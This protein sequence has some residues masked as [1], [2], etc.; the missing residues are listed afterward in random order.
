MTGHQ[1]HPGTG[2]T[3]QGEDT[4]AVSL[5]EIV[6]ACGIT[7]LQVVNAWDVRALK[8]A[9]K[10]SL[11]NDELSVIISRGACA[12]AVRR[13]INPSKIDINKCTNCGLCLAI[14]CSAIQK[15]GG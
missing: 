9:L 12:V 8:A 15:N 3:A 5:E 13:G 10:A 4:H 1:E 14:G 7:S 11:E 2:K 6:K